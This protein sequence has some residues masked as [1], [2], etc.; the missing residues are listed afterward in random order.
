MRRSV[1]NE[2]RAFKEK[3]PMIKPRAIVVSLLVATVSFTAHVTRAGD[4][5]PK[6]PQVAKLVSQVIDTYGGEKALRGA[7]GYHVTG[8]QW[9]MQNETPIQTERWFGRPDRLHRGYPD[10]HETRITAGAEGWSGASVDAV[11]PVNPVKLQAMRLQTVRLDTP[12]RLLE[13]QNEIE[14]LENDNEGRAVLRIPIDTGLYIDYHI[15]LK[16][17][18]I[19]RVTTGMTG[20]PAMEFATDYDQFQKVDGVL[21][22]FKEVTYAGGMVTSRFQVTKFEWNPKTLDQDLRPGARASN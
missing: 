15:H 22:P 8:N 2:R 20:P 13:H 4:P 21:V 17:H 10:H 7:L 14:S 16:T 18:Q 9:A 6:D 3:V 1:I 19:T 11:A 5:A 12:L